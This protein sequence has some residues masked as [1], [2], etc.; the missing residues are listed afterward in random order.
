MYVMWPD[1]YRR[2]A[3]RIVVCAEKR[4]L[5]LASCWSVAVRKGAAGRRRYGFSSELLTVNAAPARR[6]A[7]PR[8]PFSSSRTSS[9]R[10]ASR[11]AR[12]RGPAPPACRP[13]DTSRASNEP[14]SKLASEVPVLGR[15]EGDPLALA[16]DD[17]PRR[18]RLHPARGE[19]ARDLLPQ[20]GRDLVAVQPVEDAPRLLRVH[21]SLVD[22]ARVLERTRDR[23]SR[24]LVEHHAADRN[25]RLQHLDEVPGDRLSLAILV[26]REQELVRVLQVLLQLGDDLLLARVDDVVRLEPLVDVDAERAEALALA[27]R[28]R[29]MPGRGGRGCARC[30]TRRRTPCRGSPRSCAPSR[31]SRR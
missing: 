19:A 18:D 23:L 25:L 28:A 5:R 17:E 26:R 13:T 10:R 20:D 7:S 9:L 11:P 27:P 31:G 14:G 12:S 8:A 21:E 3:T 2:W 16:L 22:D 30:W 29:R 1:S 15:D 4:S 6:S 24:D